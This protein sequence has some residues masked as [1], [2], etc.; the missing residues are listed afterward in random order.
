MYQ[1]SLTMFEVLRGVSEKELVISNSHDRKSRKRI[2]AVQ[3]C[4]EEEEE[5]IWN[6]VIY[7]HLN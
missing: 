6:Q 5:E 7:F 4:K 2:A 3:R 1:V